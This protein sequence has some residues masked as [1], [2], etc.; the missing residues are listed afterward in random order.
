[1]AKVEI[2]EAEDV[3]RGASSFEEEVIEGLSAT[4]KRLSSK[5]IYD[6]QGSLLFEDIMLQPEYYPTRCEREILQTNAKAIID[7]AEQNCSSLVDL[8]AGDGSKTRYLLQEWL[9][10]NNKITY[11]PIDISE[12]ALQDLQNAL[13]YTLPRLQIQPLNAD[14][15]GALEWLKKKG[16]GNKLVLFLG[17][18][19]GNFKRNEAKAFLK[20]LYT[21]MLEGDL[22]YMGIDIKKDPNLIRDAYDDKAGVTAEFNKNLLA[23]LNRELGANIDLN[24]WLHYASYNPQSGAVN[25]YLV[26]LEEQEIQLGSGFTQKVEKDEAIHTEYS[27]KYSSAEIEE[28]R[29]SSGFTDLDQFS[30]KRSYFRGLLWQR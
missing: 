4:P 22:L 2:L 25:S 16:K 28:L 21:S 6:E 1:M 19:I 15:F 11:K 13:S 29:A 27:Y 17:G 7:L 12:D 20:Q 23:R 8:G 26:A 18:N 10:R 3:K 24:K 30:D 9:D 14:Y 5:W